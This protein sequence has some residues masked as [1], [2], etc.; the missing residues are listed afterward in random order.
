ML[1]HHIQ[2]NHRKNRRNKVCQPRVTIEASTNPRKLH[3]PSKMAFIFSNDGQQAPLVPD[4]VAAVT[5]SR[6]GR[7]SRW[8]GGAVFG[9]YGG[10]ESYASFNIMLLF[11]IF[12]SSNQQHNFPSLQVVEVRRFK[13]VSEVCK[14]TSSSYSLPLQHI[15]HQSLIACRWK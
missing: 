8:N 12:S 15:V 2:K 6:G 7:D 10:M 3:H 9:W 11:I 14:I 1:G 4:H 5:T 13:V